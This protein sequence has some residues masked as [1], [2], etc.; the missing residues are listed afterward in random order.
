MSERWRRISGKAIGTGA[1][2][3]ELRRTAAGQFTLD[4]SVTLDDLSESSAPAESLLPVDVAVSHLPEFPLEDDRI[5]ATKN[6]LGTRVENEHAEG[7]YLRMTDSSGNLIAIGAYDD[8]ERSV[9]PK[10]VLA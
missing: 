4:Q 9:H 6:G 7:E 10:V 1:H 8:A 2:L 5:G 3:L